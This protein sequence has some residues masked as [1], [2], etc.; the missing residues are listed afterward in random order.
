[1]S[2]R[3]RYKEIRRLFFFLKMSVRQ[4]Y[5][6]IRRFVFVFW[7]R[8]CVSGTKKSGGLKVCVKKNIVALY[9]SVASVN[10]LIIVGLLLIYS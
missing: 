7:T 3:Q 10:K 4:R 5:K 6:E 1:M 8:Q 9:S 2:V